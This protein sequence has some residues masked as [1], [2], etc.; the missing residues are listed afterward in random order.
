M[1]SDNSFQLLVALTQFSFFFKLILSWIFYLLK[2]YAVKHDE[3]KICKISLFLHIRRSLPEIVK[4]HVEV[5]SQVV[6]AAGVED[7]LKNVAAPAEEGGKTPANGHGPC[8]E[9][10]SHGL[11]HGELGT[12]ESVADD[13]V[14]V[15]RDESQSPDAAHTSDSTC[16]EKRLLLVILLSLSTTS[17]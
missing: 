17:S 6:V 5:K 11:A 13:V 12:V 9:A 3:E 1:F 14:T 2:S 7:A 15:E 8:N 16:K 10:H 4:T